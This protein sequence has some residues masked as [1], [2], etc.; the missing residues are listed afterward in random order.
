MAEVNEM[1]FFTVS[2]QSRHLHSELDSSGSLNENGMNTHRSHPISFE[3][4]TT[5]GGPLYVSLF[6]VKLEE[7]IGV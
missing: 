4:I 3:Q 1:S 2:C 6:N 7:G 5:R